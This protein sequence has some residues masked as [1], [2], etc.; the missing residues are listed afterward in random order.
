MVAYVRAEDAPESTKTAVDEPAIAKEIETLIAEESKLPI[1]ATVRATNKTSNGTED[2]VT[3]AGHHYGGEHGGFGGGGGGGGFGGFGDFGGF[4]GFGGG[5][6]G[7]GHGGHGG[8][9]GGHGGGGHEIGGH[10]GGHGGGG[11]GGGLHGGG[12]GGGGY[13]QGWGGWGWTKTQNYPP[14]HVHAKGHH[15]QSHGPKYEKDY[16]YHKHGWQKHHKNELIHHNH[17]KHVTLQHHHTEHQKVN[18]GSL[19][20][21]QL[22]IKTI[23]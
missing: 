5:G 22:L 16:H 10:H 20:H 23:Y 13:G 15:T 9:Q 21:Y 11:H 17:N 7:G 19:S 3:A 4:S 12:G 14:V 8:W 6:H 1:P 2:Q 18:K